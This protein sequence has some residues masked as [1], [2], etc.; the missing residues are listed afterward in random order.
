M[1]I[2]KDPSTDEVRMHA[3]SPS[4]TCILMSP[5]FA[6]VTDKFRGQN[7]DGGYGDSQSALKDMRPLV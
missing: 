7:N 1:D 3:L 4:I 5:M 2:F 6:K